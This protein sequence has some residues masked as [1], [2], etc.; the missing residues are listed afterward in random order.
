MSSDDLTTCAHCGGAN[1]S[2]RLRCAT[3][4]APNTSSRR[5]PVGAQAT[6][7]DTIRTSRSAIERVETLLSPQT[8]SMRAPENVHGAAR[9]YLIAEVLEAPYPLHAGCSVNLGRGFDNHIVL[10]VQQVSRH[11][12]TLAW[13]RDGFEVFDR[14]S[15]NGTR[16]NGELV[17]R[18]RLDDGSVLKIGPI[19]LIFSMHVLE[20]VPRGGD[21]E[22]AQDWGP[23]VGQSSFAGTLLHVRLREIWQMLELG[24]KTGCLLVQHG[25][26]RGSVTF[27]DGRA[28][29]AEFG[30]LQG[31][32]AALALLLFDAGTFRFLPSPRVDA[33]CTI[34]RSST[35]LLLEATRLSDEATRGAA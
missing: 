14:G 8:A 7:R 15:M 6:P 30:A 21:C 11:H 10:P 4:G 13:S 19:E 33:S 20:S 5:I 17:R 25:D 23:L 29:H 31:D 12:A 3:C 26:Q 27:C 1:D 18:R 35:A 32:E 34:T 16:V 28:L 22:T 2:D 9:A 24:Q